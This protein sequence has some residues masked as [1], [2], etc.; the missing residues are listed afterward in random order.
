MMTYR[1]NR[2]KSG[3]VFGANRV[4]D[5]GTETSFLISSYQWIEFLAWNAKLPV[6]LDLSDRE[7]D[8]PAPDRL[9]E[10]AAM[11]DRTA[12]QNREA[13]DL[14]LKRFTGS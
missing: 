13:L 4:N 11:K 5:N 12:E 7:P 3:K 6:P 14:L 10:L 8:A 1:I 9:K 2:D